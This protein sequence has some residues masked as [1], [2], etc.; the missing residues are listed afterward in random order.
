MQAV[1]RACRPGVQSQTA[2]AKIETNNPVTQKI[3]KNAPDATA[4]AGSG[5]AASVKSS[6]AAAKKPTSAAAPKAEGAKPAVKS[7]EATVAES[8][9]TGPVPAESKPAK[10]KPVE[11]R[12]QERP[13]AAAKMVKPGAPKQNFKA[14]EFVVYPAHGVGQIVAIEEQEVAG[15][16]LE[17]FVISFSKDKMILRCRPPNR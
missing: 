12:P 16:K 7:V 1:A 10:S 5:K 11:S 6:D 8:R 17:L 9:V 15:F 4:V 3:Q 14:S 13:G 2:D